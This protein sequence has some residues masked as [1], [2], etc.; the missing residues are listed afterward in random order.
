MSLHPVLKIV[1]LQNLSSRN[2]KLDFIKHNA[3][4]ADF[5]LIL[6]VAFD[7]IIDVKVPE[8][9]VK[10]LNRPI[11]DNSQKFKELIEVLSMTPN[12]SDRIKLANEFLVKLSRIEATIYGQALTRTLRVGVGVSALAEVLEGKITS[13]KWKVPVP[14][15]G[16]L[17]FPLLVEP[18]IGGVKAVIFKNNGKITCITR[19]GLTLYLPEMFETIDKKF[20]NIG[21]SSWVLIGNLI[22]TGSKPP[23]S[24]IYSILRD[25]LK[26]K[27]RT[28]LKFSAYDL[29][30][31]T[32]KFFEGTF[33]V[34]LKNRKVFLESLFPF[35]IPN[36]FI[37][38]VQTYYVNSTAELAT[39]IIDLQ[40][41]YRFKAVVVKD[42]K[43][44][45][46]VSTK[47]WKIIQR[48]A[49][50]KQ[51]SSPSQVI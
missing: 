16:N 31:S 39:A 14:Y 46:D 26:V 42:P 2:D 29:I 11:Q 5:V 45:Y 37:G 43:A 20:R 9:D 6:Q 22:S 35:S 34:P 25:P 27:N 51:P 24:I 40:E 13:V 32:Q 50:W 8:I 38:S 23:D 49:I 4:D 12:E 36:K 17:D 21:I 15:T 30:L 7:P 33:E 44:F 47:D 48:S 3:Y 28:D 1:E 19:K 18:A 41:F 10:P